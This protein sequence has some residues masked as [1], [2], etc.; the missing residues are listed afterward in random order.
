MLAPS[1]DGVRLIKK[2]PN[3]LHKKASANGADLQ[4]SNNNSVQNKVCLLKYS[5][6]PVIADD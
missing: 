1:L 2:Q 6:K 4:P 5:L 3:N